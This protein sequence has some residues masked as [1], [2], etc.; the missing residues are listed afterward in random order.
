MNAAPAVQLTATEVL[1]G[2]PVQAYD[3]AVVDIAVEPIVQTHAAV[4]TVPAVP[5]RDVPATSSLAPGVVV[6]IPTDP[7]LVIRMTSVG[8][9]LVVLVRFANMISP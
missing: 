8:A 5:R 3:V 9:T 7:L 6:P 1:A 2:I 4:I